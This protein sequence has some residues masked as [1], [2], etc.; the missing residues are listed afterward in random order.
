MNTVIDAT[1]IPDAI[2]WHEGLLLTPQHFQQLASRH[3]AL[4]QYS[5]SLLAPFCWGIRRF[6]YDPVRL[7]AGTFSVV[8]L[9]AVMPDGLVVSH[10]I[11]SS[12][13]DEQ[14]ELPLLKPKEL[15]LPLMK[16]R[17]ADDDGLLIHLAVA[18]TA[19]SNL[20]GDGRY[21]S[22][23]G[24]PPVANETHLGKPQIY[25]LK[26]KL[27]LLPKT[28]PASYVGFP[29]AR[30]VYQD[31]SFALDE[32]FIPPMLTVPVQSKAEGGSADLAQRLSGKCSEVALEVRKRAMQLAD[33][34]G[35]HSADGQVQDEAAFRS[36]LLSLVGALPYFEAVLRTGL[37]HP[38]SVYLALCSMAGQIAV[39]GKEMVPPPFRPYNHNDLDWTFN[40]VF[41]FIHQTLDQGVPQS[42]ET[43]PFKYQEL[44]RVY[45][46]SLFPAK[47]MTKRLAIG[48]KGRLGMSRDDVISWGES[49]RI[50][51]KGKI[52][53]MRQKRIRGPV[54][55]QVD[56]VDDIFPAN[57]FVLFSLNA[58]ASFIEPD[59]AL[60][61][62]NPDGAQPAEIVLHVMNTAASG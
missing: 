22:S 15:E 12:G 44:E 47:W 13:R 23:K 56:R 16:V 61:I 11:N 17:E 30:V 38:Y 52:S 33:G 54:R 40:P 59:K 62:E 57:G 43:H 19:D 45:E 18:L 49:C 29:L 51:S 31:S 48:I 60:Q 8:E 39:L 58:D 4:V 50:G 35:K 41:D 37:S 20:N 42:F 27:T 9:E 21:E 53:P 2:Q 14:L 36:R 55:K 5:T 1:D 46:L 25:R 6:K 24:R 10:G 7:P 28:M 32:K 26:P 3:E 34:R